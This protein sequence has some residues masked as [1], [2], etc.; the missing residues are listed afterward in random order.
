MYRILMLCDSFFCGVG[1]SFGARAPVEVSVLVHVQ[2]AAIST[3]LILHHV[4]SKH[5][6]IPFS[7]EG[8]PE[9][10]AVLGNIVQIC[11]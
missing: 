9:T 1:P 11:M 5:I 8:P 7:Q 3:H 4:V 10:G 6:L 2:E